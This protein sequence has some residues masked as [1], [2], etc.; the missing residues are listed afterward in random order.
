[1][2]FYYLGGNM[3]NEIVKSNSQ[4]PANLE[5]LSK[6]VLIGK[7]KLVSVKAEIRAMKSLKIAEEVYKQKEIEAK[8]LGGALLLAKVRI[9]EMLREIP[10]VINNPKA[11]KNEIDNVVDFDNKQETKQEKVKDLGFSQKESER[12]QQ[13]AENKAIVEYVIENS[14]D[15]P[16]QTECLKKIT[17]KKKEERKQEREETIKNTA[18]LPDSKFQVLYCD[19]PWSYSNS[20]LN[21]S[22]NSKY[23]TMTIEELCNMPIKNSIEH[24]AICFMWCTNPL[25]EDGLK[26]L[27]AWGKDMICNYK[28]YIIKEVIK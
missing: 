9:G 15:I 18:K 11:K 19:P 23:N 6:F 14:E 24:N 5:D 17:D 10:K 12:F 27:K 8:E 20:G 28:K 1:M 16:T 22:A 4:L 21:G 26:L 25:L 2:G 13:L 7:E 3:K